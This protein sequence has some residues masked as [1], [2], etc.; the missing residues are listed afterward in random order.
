MLVCGAAPSASGQS[1]LRAWM[2]IALARKVQAPS[3]QMAQEGQGQL[4]IASGWTDRLRA[5]LELAE[6]RHQ[7]GWKGCYMWSAS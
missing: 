4:L 2:L 5:Y 3:N 6:R 1:K 7:V